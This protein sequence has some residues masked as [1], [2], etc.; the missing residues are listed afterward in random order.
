MDTLSSPR[1]LFRDSGWRDPH[2]L[3]ALLKA[4]PPL[5]HAHALLLWDAETFLKR[6]PQSGDEGST[7]TPSRH[8]TLPASCSVIQAGATRTA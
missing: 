8:A 1:I 4:Y 2:S 7:K 5:E 3:N 6:M